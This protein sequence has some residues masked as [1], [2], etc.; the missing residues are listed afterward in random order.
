MSMA[1]LP[2]FLRLLAAMAF[3]LALMGGLAITLKRLGLTGCPNVPTQKKRLKLI[4]S[5]TLD[6]RR[7]AILLQRD[8]KQ[9]LVILGANSET[10]IET[11][12]TDIKALKNDNNKK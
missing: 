5:I 9:H 1:D 12:I 4:E 10:V 8:D 11:D 7:R 6:S 2:Q 3:V